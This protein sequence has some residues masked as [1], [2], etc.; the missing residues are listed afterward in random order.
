MGLLVTTLIG[1]FFI[2]LADQAKRLKCTLEEPDV[3]LCH[4]GEDRVGIL[5]KTKFSIGFLTEDSI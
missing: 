4:L 3:T 2:I 5:T 1:W